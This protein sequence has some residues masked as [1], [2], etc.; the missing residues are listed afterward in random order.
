MFTGYA[1]SYI[2]PTRL[3]PTLIVIEES[4]MVQPSELTTF[5]SKMRREEVPVEIR[6]FLF[7]DMKQLEPYNTIKTLVPVL[8]SPNQLLLD[9]GF[10]PSRLTRVYRSHPELVKILSTV[11]YSGRLTP[12]RSPE[13][14]YIQCHL[15]HD[16]FPGRNLA[17]HFQFNNHKSRR[18]V[19][20][21]ANR[22]EI[23]EISSI[24]ATEADSCHKLAQ[25]RSGRHQIEDVLN[26][27]V[28][29]KE[30][31]VT[32]KNQWILVIANRQNASQLEYTVPRNTP[33]DR[34]HWTL[35][36]EQEH[37]RREEEDALESRIT[38]K[39]IKPKLRRSERIQTKTRL[40]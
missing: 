3:F 21:R 13:E 12:G 25:K 40:K 24:N 7:G 17:L 26:R 33:S 37:L 6:Y 22:G 19:Q 20:S 36:Q 5:T 35:Q 30:T 14:D 28:T 27:I 29:F 1:S 38:F 8:K 9:S 34:N 15:P 2:L 31:W 16:I 4:T 11:F 23:Q 10:L 32:K 39:N 18:V